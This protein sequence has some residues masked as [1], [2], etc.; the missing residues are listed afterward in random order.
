MT[1]PG[2]P[3]LKKDITTVPISPSLKSI[4]KTKKKVRRNNEKFPSYRSRELFLTGESYTGPINNN[5]IPITYL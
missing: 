4:I 5:Q 3:S 2:G 1:G